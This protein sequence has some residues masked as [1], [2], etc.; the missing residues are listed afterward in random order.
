MP[1]RLYLHPLASYCQKAIIAFYEND[2]PFEPILIDLGN[3]ES[4]AKL[5]KVWPLAKFPVLVDTEN[6]RTVPEA[7]MIIEY[8]A[9]VYPGKTKLVPTDPALAE[10]TR[11]EDR[12]YDQYVHT[13][14]QKIVADKLRPDDKK[15]PFGVHEART[16]LVTAYDM[17]DRDMAKKTWAM[18][19]IFTMADCAAAPPLF[20]ANKLIPLKNAHENVA[21]YLARLSER[22]SVARTFREAEPYLKFFPG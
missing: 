9:R 1:L 8:L 15:D 3:A 17:I 18:G 5:T 16:M 7:T 10:R 20:F 4:R 14:L 19:D 21:A 11:L 2:V 6:D 22:P 13:P 12:F